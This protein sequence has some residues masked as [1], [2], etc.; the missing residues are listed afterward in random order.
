MKKFT[1]QTAAVAIT[2]TMLVSGAPSIPSTLIPSVVTSVSAA[3]SF[4]LN[5]DA[6]QPIYC[7]PIVSESKI[8]VFKDSTLSQKLNNR[9]ISNGDYCQLVALDKVNDSV[10]VK[11]PSSAS[12]TGYNTAYTKADVFFH[13]GLKNNIPV[14]HLKFDLPVYTDFHLNSKLG[15][16]SA[17]E[18]VMVI[19]QSDKIGCQI[20]YKLDSGKGYKLGWLDASRGQKSSSSTSNSSATATVPL[21]SVLYKV[22]G[23]ANRLT[24]GYDGYS[25][26]TTRGRHE[27]L[28]FKFK[29]GAAVHSILDGTITRVSSG[30]P[31]SGGLSTIAIYND[32]YDKTVVYLH[33]EPLASL[34]VGQKVSK[35]DL[36]AYESYRGCSTPHTHLEIRKGERMAAAISV[37]DYDLSNPNPASFLN[38]IGYS[39]G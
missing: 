17:N 2:L 32:T 15:S 3:E 30:S 21:S 16:V 23:N 25:Q 37:D 18:A 12:K 20:L 4:N 14:K 8:A 11:Y 9:Y 13:G 10:L 36:I 24:C 29:P 5:V 33:T 34:E 38:S 7:Y 22:S 31:G 28:D 35:G 1:K 26:K 19:C 27:G 6:N 39:I